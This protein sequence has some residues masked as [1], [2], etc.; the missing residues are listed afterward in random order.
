MKILVLGI[1]NIL[2]G[3]EGVGVHLAHYMDDKYS[4]KGEGEVCI[5][6][7]G[8]LAHSLI[9]LITEYERVFIFDCVKVEGSNVGEVYSFDFLEVPDSITW[10]GS[11]H[12]VEMLQTLGIMHL[13]GELPKTHIIGVVPYVVGENTTFSLTNEV[14]R[15]AQKMENVLLTKLKTLGA[16]AVFK[17]PFLDLNE[18]AKTSYERVL[19][20]KKE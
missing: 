4:F 19:S 16:E 8:T 6:D 14:C 15:G 13:T 1:G 5:V 12:E 3:D 7:G 9:P 11:A 18:V 20:S 10:E 17:E 2:F